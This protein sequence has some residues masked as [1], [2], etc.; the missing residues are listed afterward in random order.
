MND[1][2]IRLENLDK[3][4]RTTKAMPNQGILQNALVKNGIQAVAE[5]KQAEIDMQFTFSNEITVGKV[6]NQ[7]ASGRCWMFAGLNTL[8]LQV[9]KKCNLET[10]ELSQV[11]TLF[12]DKLEKSNYFYENILDTLDEAT[13]SRII[14][15]LLSGPL[16]DGGQWDML[17][18]IIEKYGLVPKYA[19]PETYHSSQTAMMNRLLTRKL[20]KDAATLRRLNKEGKSME[21]LRAEK[22]RMLQEIYTILCRT[23][24]TP[25]Q[26]F[27]LEYR[28]KDE[29]FFR[30]ANLTPKSFYN[31][32]ID[33]P[34][35]DYVSLI[36]APTADKPFGRTF[37]VQRLG[38]VCG[39]R[40]VTYLNVSMDAFKKA[41]V[42]QLQD[43]EVVWFGCDVG[44][45]LQGELGI[46]DLNM[47]DYEGALGTNVTMTKSDQLEYGDSLMTHAMV[48]TGVH[49]VD[50]QPM[51]W[52]VENS[53]GEKRGN[54]GVYIMSDK[55]FDQY[56]Y[57]VVVN[58][59]YLTEEQLKALDQKPIELKPWDPMGSLA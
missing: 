47:Y 36:N 59:K 10:F 22:D 39:G 56:M 9:M 14:C 23:L 17:C 53:W 1:K 35:S 29:K 19:M 31:K 34:L 38:N 44:K 37:T 46:M 50:D 16:N 13:D 2:S 28:D 5:S 15:W 41:A 24:G 32:Y 30:D 49:I 11:Y 27:D 57:Q 55:W 20:R 42:K 26:S 8:R 54:E 40:A 21:E 6:T 52:R 58:K 4:K 45:Y 51:R 43:E 3:Y 7:K 33:V 48:F 12:Y 25:P 18:N